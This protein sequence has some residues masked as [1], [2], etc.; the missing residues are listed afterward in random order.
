MHFFPMLLSLWPTMAFNYCW[1]HLLEFF[2][3]VRFQNEV[4]QNY[5]IK[6]VKLGL[7]I[8]LSNF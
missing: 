1:H 3:S 6:P 7:H 4:I 2:F 8:F 5:V